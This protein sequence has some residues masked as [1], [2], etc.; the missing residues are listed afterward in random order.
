MNKL[1]EIL[2][3]NRKFVE[4]EEYSKYITSKDPDKKMV[5]LSDTSTASIVMIED[6]HGTSMA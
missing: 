2:E 6:A 1:E 5:V 3:F 4:D